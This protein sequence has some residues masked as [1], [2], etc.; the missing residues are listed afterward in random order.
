MIHA[1]ELPRSTPEAQGIASSAI[2]SFV[3]AL[4]EKKLGVHSLILVRNGSIVADGWWKPYASHL[5]HMMFS[6]SKSFASTAIGLAIAEGR[7]SLDDR[8]L[9]FFPSYVTPEISENMDELRVRHLLSM[10]TGHAEDTFGPMATSPDEDWVRTFLSLPITYP[11]GTH[12]LYNTGA[13]FMLSAILQSLTGQ[14]LVEYLQPRLFEP[15]GIETPVWEANPSGISL[16]GT[17]LRLR[18][19]D[20]A[21]FG[22]LYLQR[23]VWNGQRIVPEEWIEDATSVHISNAG[24]SNPDWSQGYGFQFWRCRHNLYRGDGAFGQFCIVFPEQNA[25]LAMT[26][27]TYDMQGILNAVW[28][29]LL[30]GIK[31]EALPENAQETEALKERL[32]HLMLPL[33]PQT[34]EV[35]SSISARISKR[36]IQFEPNKLH[37]S[38]AS[39]AFEADECI[40]T[41]RDDQGAEHVVRC[42]YTDW[43][44]GESVVWKRHPSPS[45]TFRVAACGAWADD[46]TFVMNWQYIETPFR[47]T[48]TTDFGGDEV[49]LSVQVDVSFGD[50][51]AEQVHGRFV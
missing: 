44:P 12:F 36:T 46:H 42:G 29:H 11:P 31:T 37:I 30:P 24:N 9:S 3:D 48:I 15:L 20:L 43:L 32:A 10:S 38:E 35:E 8:V 33:L 40:F 27:G 28:E 17:G 47:Y 21:K 14:T 41:M 26:S 13:T 39:F 25:V 51:R 16:G 4:E 2:Q 6:V 23:G 19:S 34:Q 7:L 5:P 1:I 22:Q 50:D 49:V 18:T 45:E